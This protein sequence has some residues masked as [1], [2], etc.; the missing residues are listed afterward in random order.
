MK[1]VKLKTKLIK[2]IKHF[3]SKTNKTKAVLGLSGGVDSA[4]C[5]FLLSKALK[6]RN[7]IAILMPVK[8]VSSKKNTV[9]AKKLAQKLGINYF[10]VPLD[11]FI[12]PFS[13]LSWKSSK[14]AGQ[15]LFAR[16]RAVILYHFANS[17]N[18]LVCGTGNKSEILLGYYTKHGDGA[19]DFFPLGGVYKTNVLKLA[20]NIDLPIEFIEKP[21]SAELWVGQTDEKEIGV[22]YEEIDDILMAIEKNKSKSQIIKLGH[23]KKSVDRIFLLIEQNKHKRERP[24][25][26][27]S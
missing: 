14:R 27:K 13:H 20:K 16:Q 10:V 2:Q 15:N 6:P 24:P 7:I 19:A 8:G 22:T 12:A 26:L 9:D 3:F 23:S 1:N 17:K 25:I 11:R 18:T 5:A 4:V 21:P